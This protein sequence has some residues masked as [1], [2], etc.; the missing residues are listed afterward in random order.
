MV[1][2]PK[3]SAAGAREIPEGPNKPTSQHQDDL[4]R[5]V[6]PIIQWPGEI[7]TRIGG[8]RNVVPTRAP[9]I[10]KAR[11]GERKPGNQHQPAPELRKVITCKP[12]PSV[13]G[14]CEAVS[15]DPAT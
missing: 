1:V 15:V 2:E 6:N 9:S 8:A 11:A 3:R 7:L 10:R 5:F 12:K 13:L 4:R 14:L